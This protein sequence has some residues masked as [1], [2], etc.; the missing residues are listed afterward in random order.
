VVDLGAKRAQHVQA[1]GRRDNLE[2][3]LT[4]T[5]GRT[6]DVGNRWRRGRTWHRRMQRP[7]GRLVE[8]KEEPAEDAGGRVDVEPGGGVGASKG[9]ECDAASRR[10]PKRPPPCIEVELRARCS[11]E[12]STVSSLASESRQDSGGGAAREWRGRARVAGSSG[13]RL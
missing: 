6:N 9:A 2:T 8:A 4:G 11:R 1:V 3:T 5:S 10:W 12:M 7:R 13:R